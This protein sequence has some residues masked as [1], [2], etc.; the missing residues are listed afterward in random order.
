MKKFL[1]LIAVSAFCL[2]G[3]AQNFQTV[4]EVDDVCTQ[5]LGFASNYQ[6]EQAV[7]DI[8]DQVA[9]FRNFVIQECPNINNAVAVNLKNSQGFTERYIL[10]DSQFFQKI[11]QG[12]DYAAIFILAHEIGHHLNGHSLNNVGS[13]HQFELEADYFAGRV[14]G[15]MGHTLEQTLSALNAIT[16]EK[17]TRTHPAKADRISKATEG[18]NRAT[19]RTN[20]I[21]QQ[22]KNEELALDAFSKGETAYARH[23]YTEALSHFNQAKDLGNSEAF[24]YL[25]HIYY[26]GLG[27]KPDFRKA[28]ELAREGYDLGSITAIYQLGIYLYNGIGTPITPDEADRLFEKNY[29]FNWFKSQYD[30]TKRDF[31]AYF[32]GLIYQDGKGVNQNYAEAAHWYK[33]AAEA[34]DPAAQSNLGVLYQDGTGVSQS[35]SEAAQWYRKAAEKEF[36]LAQ[37]NLGVLYHNG[38]GVTQSNLEALYWYGQA[39]EQGLVYAQHNVGVLYYNGGGVSQDYAQAASWFRKS[40]DNGFPLSQYMLG[41]MYQEGIGVARNDSEAFRWYMKAAVQDYPDAQVSVGILYHYGTG[42]SRNYYEAMN[43]YRKAAAYEDADA[44]NNI[45]VMY[46]NGEGVAQSIEEAVYWYKKA[47]RQGHSL[48]QDN[49][50]SLGERW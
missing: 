38:E 4:E 27:V 40:A 50:R 22:E 35:F 6:A 12:N 21:T 15:Q 44:Q 10:Y 18:F 29:Q 13:T 19:G 46:Q 48:A 49:L 33:R 5:A 8:L 39:A 17:A 34:G 20:V 41:V 3:S 36:A 11:G 23:N 31:Y 43:W 45:G 16:Y 24:S 37:Y 32:L 26:S 28:Y 7:D 1:L 2:N 30:K 47:A 42:V 25:S 9:L 14:M